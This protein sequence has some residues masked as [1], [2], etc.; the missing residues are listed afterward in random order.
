MNAKEIMKKE[1]WAKGSG[2]KQS[3]QEILD[4]MNEKYP[5][6]KAEI[7]VEMVRILSTNAR[8]VDQM[9]KEM[10]EHSVDAIRTLESHNKGFNILGRSPMINDKSAYSS[11]DNSEEM[12]KQDMQIGLDLYNACAEYCRIYNTAKENM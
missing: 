6:Q 1:G 2:T 7:M 9:R 12:V 10:L 8:N 5:D 4:I 3:P 11:A